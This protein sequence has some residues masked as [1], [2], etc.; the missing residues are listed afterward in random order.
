MTTHAC[1]SLVTMVELAWWTGQH[2]HARVMK[3][4]VDWNVR[5][6]VSM[7]VILV[8]KLYCYLYYYSNNINHDFGIFSK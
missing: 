1:R 8:C 2:I 3:S 6:K 7:F 4:T 5:M